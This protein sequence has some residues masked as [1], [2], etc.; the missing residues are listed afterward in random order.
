MTVYKIPHGWTIALPDNWIHETEED[1]S[2]FYPTDS[3]LTIRITPFQAEKDGKP[4]PV[5]VMRVVFI[6]N[7][8]QSLYPAEDKEL[9]L[10]NYT[11]EVFKGSCEE[12]G[13][14]VFWTAVG[15]TAPGELLSVNIFGT[16]EAE[17]DNALIFL[18]NL[19][20]EQSDKSV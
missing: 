14:N 4:A 5:E 13:E 9:F 1:Q 3:D 19:K 2:V 11:V 15:Y 16:S 8:A 7:I 18:K 10:D 17:C 12:D 6:I 20:K